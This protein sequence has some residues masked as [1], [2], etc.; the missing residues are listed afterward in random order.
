MAAGVRLPPS[1]SELPVSFGAVRGARAE[2]ISAVLLALV[3]SI[4]VPG[5]ARPRQIAAKPA[6]PLPPTMSRHQLFF[7]G[8]DPEPIIVALILKRIRDDTGNLVEAKAFVA[9][10]G[11]W[12]TPF[13]ERKKVDSWPAASLTALATAWQRASGTRQPRLKVSEGGRR[14]ELAIRRKQGGLQID[15]RRLSAVGVGVD[16][17]G[18]IRWR[19]GPARLT[20]NGKRFRGR[21]VVEHLAR[22]TTPWPRFGRFEMWLHSRADGGLLFGRVAITGVEGKGEALSISAAGTAKVLPFEVASASTRRDDKTGFSLPIGWQIGAPKPGLMRRVAGEVGRGE[23]PDGGPALYDVSLAVGDGGPVTG[24]QALV[25]HLQDAK[26]AP[27]AS[28]RSGRSRQNDNTR[29]P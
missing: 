9:W 28:K 25:F 10:N 26:A 24:G 21:L 18:P 6:R 27:A 2:L 12:Q 4:A 17:H 11:R 23:S 8:T 16:P 15:A 5:L 22:A 20:I 7:A 3:A 1:A 14:L 29:A 13:W 19:A